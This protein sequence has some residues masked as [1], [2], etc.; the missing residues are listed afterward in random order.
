MMQISTQDLKSILTV[1]TLRNLAGP[2][3][4]WPNI[5]INLDTLWHIILGLLAAEKVKTLESYC[6]LHLELPGGQVHPG[7]SFLISP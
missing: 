3:V 5:C 1:K 4:V 6:Y 2:R 7:G